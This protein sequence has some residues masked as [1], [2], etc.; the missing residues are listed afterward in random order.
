MKRSEVDASPLCLRFAVCAKNS[1]KKKLETSWERMHN[2]VT[3]LRQNSGHEC[4]SP[5][6]C[7]LFM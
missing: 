7:T 2:T 1:I 5:N 4:L 6:Y 3:L